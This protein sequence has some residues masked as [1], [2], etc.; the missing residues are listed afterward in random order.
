MMPSDISWFGCPTQIHLG[1]GSH[2]RIADVL[3]RLQ[4][5]R[6]FIT[7]DPALVGGEFHHRV[8]AVLTDR[9]TVTATFTEIEPDPSVHTVERALVV[10]RD[11]KAQAVLAVG[12]GSTID[13]AKAVAILMTQGGRIQDYEGGLCRASQSRPPRVP[14]RRSQG[15][16]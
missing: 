13:V 4:V 12:G 7:L 10:A 8:E 9:R 5:E 15:R 14:G 6:L 11:L 2:G 1:L 16:V 3:D